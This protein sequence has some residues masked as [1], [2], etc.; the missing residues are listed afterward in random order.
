MANTTL[1]NSETICDL[2]GQPLDRRSAALLKAVDKLLTVRAYYSPEHEQYHLASEKSCAQ[3]VEAI[4]P[5]RAMTIEVTASGMMVNRR[6]VDPGHRNVRLLHDLLVPL[7]IAQL[8]I[9]ADLTPADLRQAITALQD[10][11]QSLGTTT[12]F[13]EIVIKNLP[14][15]VS[16]ASKGVVHKDGTEEGGE[17]LRKPLTLDELLNSPT[18][19]TGEESTSETE[20]LARK[21]MELVNQI[22]SNLEKELS[23]FSGDGTGV[24]TDATPENI[25]A[26]REALQ[27][28][29]EVNPDPRDLARLIQ[30]AKKALDLSHDPGS[31]DL[32]FSILKK[33]AENG[34]EWKTRAR[35]KD[36]GSSRKEYR[37]TVEQLKAEVGL[38]ASSEAPVPKG[39]PSAMKDYL[40][41][42]LNLIG[43]ETSEVLDVA[44]VSHLGEALAAPDLT[45]DDLHFC[46]AAVAD[47]CVHANPIVL[48][49]VLPAYCGALISAQ[50]VYLGG[51]WERLWEALDS[52]RRALVWPHL[53]NDLLLGLDEKLPD[54]GTRL[55]LAVAQIDPKS[56]LQQVSRMECLEAFRTRKSLPGLMNLS[57][58][59]MY[60]VHLVLMRSS[61]GSEHGPRLHQHLR[62]QP[63]NELAEVLLEAIGPHQ[64]SYDNLYLALIRQGAGSTMTADFR[65]MAARLIGE[66]LISLSGEGR[67]GKWAGKAVAWLGN[68]DP[69]HSL[70]LLTEIRDKRKFF[71]F[72]VWP[73]KLRNLAE[74]IIASRSTA[75]EEER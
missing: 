14:A 8:N 28:L 24:R 66:T 38:L 75:A 29:V 36:K 53:V 71:F 41:I 65:R 44:L 69:D 2:D 27:R 54:A 60:P 57:L 21:F 3:M 20:M 74:V 12:G 73:E 11:R 10:H 22:L 16:T 49:R 9:G 64:P 32:V 4:L 72:R 30:H 7:N 35:D 23:D 25:R 62:R 26:L 68:L 67:K 58:E 34:G 70:P 56:A 39:R 61:L 48:D 5:D 43:I 1:L 42:I 59:S 33:E 40:G 47:Y 17:G 52:G 55:W 63:P 45:R 50:P 15:T 31:V 19:G 46:A 51:F 13:R 6:L 37:L 18:P